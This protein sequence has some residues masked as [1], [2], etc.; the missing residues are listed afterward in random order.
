MTY[1]AKREGEDMWRS[2]HPTSDANECIRWYQQRLQAAFDAGLCEGA[3]R[4]RE[5]CA[6]TAE[7]QGPPPNA[8]LMSESMLGWRDGV[9]VCAAAIRA[10]SKGGG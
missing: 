5:A 2:P 9:A 1:D 10:R 3:E 8:L 6:V 7:N 4:E